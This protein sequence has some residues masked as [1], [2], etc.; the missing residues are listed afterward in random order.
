MERWIHDHRRDHIRLNDN[1]LRVQ[2]VGTI[3]TKVHRTVEGTVKTAS[4]VR[5]GDK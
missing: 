3:R 2:H 5:E 1:R 4:L